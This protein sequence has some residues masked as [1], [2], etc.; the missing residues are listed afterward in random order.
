[1]GRIRPLTSHKGSPGLTPSI[2]KERSVFTEQGAFP[3]HVSGQVAERIGIGIVCG[4]ILP[5][6]PL[7]SEMRIC[8]L[9][10]VSRTVVREAIRMLAAKGFLETRQKSGSRVRSPEHWNHLDPDV[11]RWRLETTDMDSYLAKLFQLRDALDPT[12][13]AIAA[14]AATAEDKARIQAA[15]DGMAAA[16]DNEAFVV[17]DIDFHKSIY[18]ATRNEFFWPIAQMFE[19]ALRQSFRIAATG[20]HRK[21]ALAEHREVMDAI[22]AGDADRAREATITLLGHSATDLVKIRGRDPFRR[23]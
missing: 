18:V 10:G 23:R 14:G 22:L 17:A 20:D 5:G 19:I 12:A 3:R 21:R 11:L 4:D 16:R 7:P 8:E 15:F 1:M 2:A 6:E 13:S 9:M